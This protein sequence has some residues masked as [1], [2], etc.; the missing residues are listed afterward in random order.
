MR[1]IVI[2]LAAAAG[3]IL[4]GAGAAAADT[5]QAPHNSMGTFLISCPDLAP[6]LVT[7]PPG[8]FATVG[9]GTPVVVAPQ[10]LFHG[11]MPEDLVMTCSITNVSTGNTVEGP[12]LIAPTTR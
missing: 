7:S 6:F 2:I 12:I 10:G 11:R 1:R 8:L 9:V 4:V 3:S 5:P